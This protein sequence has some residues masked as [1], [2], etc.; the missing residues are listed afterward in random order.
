MAFDSMH[1]VN[2]ITV[3]IINHQFI[4]EII[5]KKSVHNCRVSTMQDISNLWVRAIEM[6][7][8]SGNLHDQCICKN[9]VGIGINNVGIGAM[10]SKKDG[11]AG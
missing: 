2:C 9:N 3:Y 4:T 11:C 5:K 1:A 7:Y 6:V 10:H 8:G